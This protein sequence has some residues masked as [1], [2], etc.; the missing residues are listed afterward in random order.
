MYNNITKDGFWNLVTFISIQNELKLS[1]PRVCIGNYTGAERNDSIFCICDSVC[2]IDMIWR[3]RFW[4]IIIQLMACHLTAP[5]HYLI[6]RWFI[7]NLTQRPN[8]NV[9]KQ[10]NTIWWWRPYC[11]N[12][13]MWN[14]S[15]CIPLSTFIPTQVHFA[16]AIFRFRPTPLVAE[17]ILIYHTPRCKITPIAPSVILGELVSGGW[18]W[19]WSDDN[20]LSSHNIGLRLIDS[21]IFIQCGA[22]IPRTIFIKILIIDTP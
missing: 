12:F 18:R 16:D 14:V 7:V 11:S 21:L 13:D 2:P 19:R 8:F 9:I 15:Q 20:P 10:W 6:Q 1:F 22:V 4:I 5:G 3:H 17:Y